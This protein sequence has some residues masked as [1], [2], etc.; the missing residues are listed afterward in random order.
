MNNNNN[1]ATIMEVDELQE[2]RELLAMMRQRALDLR[3]EHQAKF[4]NGEPADDLLQQYM[5]AARDVEDLRRTSAIMFPGVQDFQEKK[6]IEAQQLKIQEMPRLMGPH[7]KPEGKYDGLFRNVKQFFA[8]L[9]RYA[10]M[11]ALVVGNNYRVHYERQM[12][13][14]TANG[15]RVAWETVKSWLIEY[16]DTPKQR[17]ESIRV[18]FKQQARE[19]ETAT[20]YGARVRELLGSMEL[21]TISPDEMIF[22]ALCMNLSTTWNNQIMLALSQRHGG[23]RTASIHEMIDFFN[24]NIVGEGR[25][26]RRIE[27]PHAHSSQGQ[28]PVPQRKGTEASRWATRRRRIACDR[29]GGEYQPGHNRVCPTPSEGQT[30]MRAQRAAIRVEQTAQEREPAPVD[31]RMTNPVEQMVEELDGQNNLSDLSDIEDMI[32]SHR[33]IEA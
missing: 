5:L 3:R 11:L 29:C 18:L 26:R 20:E 24:E 9:E 8:R 10:H 25:D 14:A 27:T 30:R 23:I 15:N 22:N 12:V 16:C 6:P 21:S 17:A 28:G 4:K 31:S 33:G 7:E 19:G 2:A 13:S 32:Q 1:N